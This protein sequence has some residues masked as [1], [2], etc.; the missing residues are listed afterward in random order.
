MSNNAAVT[1]DGGEIGRAQALQARACGVAP[2]V[3]MNPVL[4]KPQS[5]IGAQIVVQGRVV[6]AA[7]GARLPGAEAEADGAPCSTASRASRARPTSCWSKAPAAP[8]RST[9]APT[10][11]PT[12]ASRAPPDCPVVLIGD[13]DRGG[14]I[15][16][17][18][19]TRAVLEPDDA[20]MIV[21]FLVNKFR[22]DASLFDGRH[23]A[24]STSAPAGARFGL[25]P[26]FA[27]AA[28]LPAEDAVAL[29][30]AASRAA[31]PAI[32]D[33]RADACRTSPISTISIR[34]GWSPSVRL[35]FVAPGEPLP[36]CRSRHP[37]RHQ[38]DASPTSRSFRA[39]G[40]DIDLLAHV[41][42]GG[43]VLGLCG[44]Y[45]M[46]GRSDRRPATA[47]KGRPA[48]VAGLGLLDVETDARPARRRS[49]RSRATRLANGAP[50]AGYE[51][52][53]GRTRGPGL[54]AA[55]AALSP[56]AASDGAM[57][58]RRPR[59]AAAMCM[60]C[61]PTTRSARAWLAAL[62]ASVRLCL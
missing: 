29:D 31:A 55:A 16:Q 26:F 40:W 5:E 37:A 60:A 62:G 11:S 24:A 36:P 17:I 45:Q 35:V 44:G 10:T 23:G 21:G 3:H 38:G 42:R 56:T 28:R 4:L 2:S 58:A 50:F 25:V 30:A 43:R 61:S 19:G 59:R 12:W 13:I 34:C 47:S 1:A 8:R 54:R 53:V 9:C 22:G 48:T 39:Q 49:R 15:A 41:R 18:V 27:A 20:A 7:Q 52:H 33:R 6:G 14:V 46:L 32:D 51:M 57:S